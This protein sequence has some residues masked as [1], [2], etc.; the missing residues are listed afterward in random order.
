MDA[1]NTLKTKARLSVTWCNGEKTVHFDEIPVS[2][3][4]AV[5]K[6]AAEA[7]PHMD[8]HG[9]FTRADLVSVKEV[10]HIPEEMHSVYVYVDFPEQDEDHWYEWSTDTCS[11]KPP[12]IVTEIHRYSKP[13]DMWAF[14]SIEPDD[15]GMWSVQPFAENT[16]EEFPDS[17]TYKE[18]GIV[19][20]WSDEVV[21]HRMALMVTGYVQTDFDDLPENFQRFVTFNQ[22]PLEWHERL[23]AHDPEVMKRVTVWVKGV[24]P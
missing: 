13:E 8:E 6:L 3:E 18:T 4:E 22:A 20:K 5:K 15:T 1:S 24:M 14:H 11:H 23:A 12:Y 19:T 21:H 10:A 16:Y 2:P 17:P 7:S 9:P